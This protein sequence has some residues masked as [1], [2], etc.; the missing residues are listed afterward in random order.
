LRGGQ[1]FVGG[2][3]GEAVYEWYGPVSLETI[4]G[5]GY[6]YFLEKC[7]ASE[8]GRNFVEWDTDVAAASVKGRILDGDYVDNDCLRMYKAVAIGNWGLATGDGSTTASSGD[9]CFGDDHWEW[10]YSIGEV[11]HPRCMA[12]LY[13]LKMAFGLVPQ[14]VNP[15]PKT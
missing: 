2:D 15:S 1:L 8:V 12:H 4:A 5:M 14:A 7:Q 10:T 13:G 9:E 3:L 11:I 6:S